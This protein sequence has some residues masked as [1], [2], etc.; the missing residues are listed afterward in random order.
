MDQSYLKN[1]DNTL[2]AIDIIGDPEKIREDDDL[3]IKHYS[4]DSCKVVKI[5]ITKRCLN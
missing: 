3:D 1:Q 4:E 5:T 2:F